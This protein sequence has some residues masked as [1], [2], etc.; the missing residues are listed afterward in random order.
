MCEEARGGSIALLL[1]SP[2]TERFRAVLTQNS[3]VELAL[4][5]L[6]PRLPKSKYHSDSV[7][8]LLPIL[9]FRPLHL[10]TG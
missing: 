6:P 8:D 2:A 3:Y 9:A 10:R 7:R 4:D 5:R 1:R